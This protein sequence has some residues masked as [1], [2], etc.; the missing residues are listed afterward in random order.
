MHTPFATSALT[1]SKTDG[2][3][4]G[5]LHM[6]LEGGNKW[7]ITRLNTSTASCSVT[8]FCTEQGL[9]Q[10]TL[11]TLS[12]SIILGFQDSSKQKLHFCRSKNYAQTSHRQDN[13][14]I[15][16]VCIYV[17][18]SSISSL[19]LTQH[20]LT[21]TEHSGKIRKKKK[22]LKHGSNNGAKSQHV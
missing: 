14:N 18:L 22:W 19:S 13:Q 4:A 5:N 9:D 15:L 2:T 12:N 8:H 10:M 11:Q 20:Y 6:K 7:G 3:S 1:L 17:C 16:Y 21:I